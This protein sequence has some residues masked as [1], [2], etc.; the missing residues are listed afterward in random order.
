MLID[1][2]TADMG[3][4]IVAYIQEIGVETIDY[5]I[6]THPHADHIGGLTQVMEVFDIGALYMP[7]GQPF[8]SKRL[9]RCWK[10]QNRKIWR[11]ALP[12]QV[13]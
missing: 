5:V 9:K 6:A 1:A 3:D 7:L 10:W 4:K 8:L 2:G 13:W 11:C 12:G